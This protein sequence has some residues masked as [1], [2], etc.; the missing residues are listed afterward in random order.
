MKIT[1]LNLAGY[2]QWPEREAKIVS[3][4]N[5]SDSDIVFFQE[6]K[7]DPAISSHTQSVHITNV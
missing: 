1:T 6:V 4:L 2:V 3:F 7:F 5:A